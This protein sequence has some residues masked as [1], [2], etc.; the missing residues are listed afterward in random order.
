AVEFVG[1][2]LDRAFGHADAAAGAFVLIDGAGLFLD[3]DLE[4]ADVP[5][6]QFDF[7]VGVE[8]DLGM[9]GDVDHLGGHDA[10]GAVEGREGLGELGHVPA[11]GGFPL[12]QD[13]FVA[14]VSDVEGCLDAGDAAADDKGPLGDRDGD[15][16]EDPVLL[17]PFDHHADDFDRF[18]GGFFFVFVDPGAVLADV[19]HLAQERIEAGRFDGF[20]DGFLMHARAA[21]GD[22]DM[23]E[24]L[25]LDGFLEQVL[26]GIGT[27]VFVFDGEGDAG[28]PAYFPGYALDVDGTGDVLAAVADEYAYS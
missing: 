17:D 15:G 2:L 22:D 10:L 26:A 23:G 13:D 20:A 9:V 16:G 11:D 4:V 5:F 6:D 1:D 8:F 24:F 7:G 14:G 19:G 27:H 18:L 28:E 3:G 25:L 21:G 12:D